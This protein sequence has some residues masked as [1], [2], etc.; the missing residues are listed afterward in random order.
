MEK[1]TNGK[2]IFLL[3]LTA[4]VWGFAF[5]AQSVGAEHVNTLVYNGVRF[6]L[7][8]LSLIPV[9]L[10][11]ERNATDKKRM[12][13]T[14]IAGLVCGVV[15]FSA[16]TLQQYGIEL[17]T[18][19]GFSDSSGRAGFLTALYMVI[20]PL[21]GL[22]MKKRPSVET[23]MGVAFAVCGL[24]LI[25]FTNGFSVSFEDLVVI[26]CAFLFAIHIVV[27]DKFGDQ[28]YS[29]RFAMTQFAVSAILSGIFVLVGVS[30]GM[31]EMNT[32]ADL[33]AGLIPILYGGF[34]SVG[35]AYTCQ[36]LGQKNAEPAFASI[37]L[38]TESMFSIIGG[39]LILGETMT[40]RG[41]VGCGL[42]FAGVILTQVKIFKRKKA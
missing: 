15:L 1:K 27:I 20:V 28:M 10:L 21:I 11:F 6:T 24:F 30:A 23:W 32:L 35:V 4:V 31:M 9:I 2:G 34:L 7:G 39:A 18:K 14:I 40:A 5:V 33:K 37:I 22:F 17:Y 36:I 29:L 13:T 42:I 3:I 8:C 26:G 16:S 12:K 19:A 41:Y 25:S 38:S